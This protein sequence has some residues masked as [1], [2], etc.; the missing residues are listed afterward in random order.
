VSCDNLIYY[1]K[2]VTADQSTATDATWQLP[3]GENLLTL[4]LL[5]PNVLNQ[6]SPRIRANELD[7][8]DH[9][10]THNKVAIRSQS[11]GAQVHRQICRLAN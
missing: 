9:L 1:F 7:M 10:G 6:V 11:E 8:I 4:A 5:F 2:R 3:V